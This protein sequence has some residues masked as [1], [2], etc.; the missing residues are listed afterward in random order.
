MTA[1][2]VYEAAMGAD[3][4]RL[5]PTVQ[6]FHRIK[7]QARLSGTVECVPARHWLGRWLARALGAPRHAARG[8][9]S[10]ELEAQPAQ[11]HWVRHFPGCTMASTLRLIDGQLVERLGAA[12]LVF[13]LSAEQ[14]A[15]HMHLDRMRFFGVPCPR[16]LLPRLAAVERGEGDR[17][18]FQVQAWV[19]GLGCVVNYAGHLGLKL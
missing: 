1:V 10:F 12:T 8:P 18:D 5:H 14:G 16:W 6:R 17:F 2:S 7:G 15:L 11:E 9:L 3:F 4:G 13:R 19:P